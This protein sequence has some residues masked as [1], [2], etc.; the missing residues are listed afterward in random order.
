[1]WEIVLLLESKSLFVW[2]PLTAKQKMTSLRPLRL[3]GE[4]EGLI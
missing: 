2:R 1:M 3:C 4:Y